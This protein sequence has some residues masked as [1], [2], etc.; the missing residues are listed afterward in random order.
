MSTP[1]GS[2]PVEPAGPPAGPAQPVQPSG[3]ADPGQPVDPAAPPPT[4]YRHPDRVTYVRCT[5]CGRPICPEDMIPAAVGFQCPDDVRAGNRGV[6]VAR[7]AFGGRAATGDPAVVTKVLLALNVL[8]LVL[9]HAKPSLVDDLLMYSGVGGGVPTNG[10]AT[11]EWYRLLTAA[12]LHQQL[13]HLL[14]N[15]YAL[16]L[17]GPPLEAAFGRLRFAALYLS[18][19]LAGG[20]A[21]YAFS[22]L[23]SGS[24]GASGA[25]FGLFAGHLV[26]NRRLGRENGGLWVLLAVNV[27]FGFTVADIDWRAHAG[28]FVGGLVAAAA[29]AYA[30]RRGRQAAQ[31]A[32]ILLVVLVSLALTTWRSVDAL[33]RVQVRASAA[34]VVRCEVLHPAHA[35]AYFLCV[36]AGE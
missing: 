26:V 5:R 25:V 1:Y 18:A 11:G 7:T 21:S 35:E 22:P 36:G 34:D 13:L 32:G 16:W 19:A 28:G 4:C 9:G 15:M 29:L 12:F 10:V 14:L 6:R 27:V 23:S 2:G 30:P 24:L 31:A 3:P 33:D 17:F 8:V 20:A